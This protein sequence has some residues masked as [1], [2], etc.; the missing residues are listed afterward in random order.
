MWDVLF[1][2]RPGLSFTI[3]AG[4]CQ[5]NHFRVK[6]RGTHDHILLPQIR[7]SLKPGELGTR[8]YIPQEQGG[9]F[10]PAGTGSPFRRLIR[11]A[12]LRWRYSNPPTHGFPL[13]A[14][15]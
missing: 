2:E 12:G 5:R 13:T 7:D 11:L 14:P 9:P 3:Y 1:D 6:S 15:R 4:P 10:I 8:I